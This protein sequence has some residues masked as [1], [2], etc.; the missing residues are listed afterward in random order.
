MRGSRSSAV[1]VV[2]VVI[3][4]AVVLGGRPAPDVL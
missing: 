2:T 4:A 3:A 1:C